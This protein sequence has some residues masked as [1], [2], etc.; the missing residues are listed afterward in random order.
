MK[1]ITILSLLAPVVVQ[2]GA[3]LT[4]TGASFELNGTYYYVSPYSQ[5]KAHN[6]PLSAEGLPHAFGLTPVTIVSGQTDLS[7]TALEQL[8]QSWAA[9]DDVWQPAFLSTVLLS[10][11]E[12]SN[13]KVAYHPEIESMVLS[14]AA[15]SLPPGPYFLDVFSGNVFQAFRLYD[16]FNGAFTTSVLQTPNDTFQVLSAQ[17]P[18]SASLTIGVPSRLYFT[19]TDEKPLAGVRFAVKDLFSLAGI[20][21]SNGNRAWWNLYPSA[22]QTAIAIQNLIDAGAIIIGTQKLSQFANGA[23]PTADWVDYHAPFNPRG[24]GY[25]DPSSSSAGASASIASYSWLDI[26]VG[27][28]TGGSVRW[29]A[30]AVGVYSNR[31]SRG[32]VSLEGAM[33]MS[34]T[35]DTA[36]FLLR[37]PALWDVANSAMFK[38]NYTSLV[39]KMAKYP[40]EV[41]AMGFPNETTPAGRILHEFSYRLGKFLNVNVKEFDLF[42]A[43]NDSRPAEIVDDIEIFTNLTY[44]V[45]ISKEQIPLVREPFFTDYAA[46]H[47]KRRPF[48]DP[49]TK[50]R[51]DWSDSVPDSWLGDARRNKTLFGDWWNTKIQTRSEDEIQCTSNFILYPGAVGDAPSPRNTY[52]KSPGPPLGWFTGLISCFAE[53]PD[54]TFPLGE[55]LV[56]STITGQNETLPVTV[57][58]MAAK[59]CDGV[60][61]KLAADLLAAGVLKVPTTG[62]SMAMT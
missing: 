33:P 41:Y 60:L 40:T 48:L 42:E 2:A 24:D 61:A 39:G 38:S 17:I 27:S 28:D 51:W 25:N 22:N 62:S 50:A 18:N 21:K 53:S 32:L 43:W 35:L 34:P 9:K 58:V 59:G 54:S 44:S 29:P 16:D 14:L 15:C 57:N 7:A 20:K 8:F 47:E 49:T 3:R 13:E 31:P 23:V 19:P 46:A 52:L 12:K 1:I 11:Q 30:A 45:L 37:D 6:G 36:G 26:V 4:C 5:G 10:G 56:P 55:I